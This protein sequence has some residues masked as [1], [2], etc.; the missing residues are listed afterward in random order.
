LFIKFILTYYSDSPIINRWKIKLILDFTFN[1]ALSILNLELALHANNYGT[2]SII[3]NIWFLKSNISFIGVIVSFIDSE[4]NL[5]YKLI[6]FEDLT[7]NHTGIYIFEEF[8]N[9]I[10]SFLSIKLENIFRYVLL[11]L[12]I[13]FY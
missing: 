8:E 7:I 1:N 6:G 9:I 3:F 11:S 2:F 10:I 5:N 4:F 12:F 13:N